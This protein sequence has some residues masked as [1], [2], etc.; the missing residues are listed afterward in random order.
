MSTQDRSTV[1]SKRLC[2]ALLACLGG[3]SAGASPVD[4]NALPGDAP[5]IAAGRLVATGATFTE[6]QAVLQALGDRGSS[7][8]VLA[9]RVFAGSFEADASCDLDSDGDGLPDCVE[10]NTGVFLDL[11]DTGTDPFNADTDGDGLS[12]GDEVLGTLDGL[13]L[14][15][16]GVDPLRRDLLIEYDWFD[17]SLECGAHSHAPTDATL[18]RVAAVFAAAPVTNPDGSQGINLIQDI[19]QGGALSGG[20][21]ID[22]YPANLPGTFDATHAAIKR[23]NFADNRRGYFHYVLMAHRYDGGSSSSGYAEVIGDDV[24]VSL[25]CLGT[26]NNVTR[27]ILHE[28]GHNLGLQHGGFEACNG[29]PNYNSLLNYR[30]QFSGLDTLCSGAG[31]DLSD[32]YSSGGRA[33]ID[34]RAIDEHEGVCGFPSIDWNRD[35]RIEFALAHDLNPQHAASCEGETHGLLHDFDDWANITLL[36]ILDDHGMLKSI[37]QTVACDAPPPQN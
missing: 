3:G 14:P 20:N 1:A 29:K 30:Y 22:G 35:G 9:E 37:Q 12:D 6:R 16:L 25:Y 4:F 27:T 24:I 10:T 19:G 15:A 23:A 2:L 32:G 11:T 8:K 36:G 5:P 26:E 21:R 13:D 18:A 34:E 31:N 33:S 7:S 17:D 28:I